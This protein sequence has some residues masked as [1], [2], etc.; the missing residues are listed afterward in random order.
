VKFD[1][2]GNLYALDSSSGEVLQV[3]TT[4]G[5]LTRIAT[6]Q[7]GLDNLAFDSQDRLFVSNI[8]T[9][10]V[11]EVLSDG[12]TRTVSGLGPP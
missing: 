6:L 12:T 9:G 11:V 7:A 5:S 4:T 1:S 2:Q 3:D 10:I 8:V